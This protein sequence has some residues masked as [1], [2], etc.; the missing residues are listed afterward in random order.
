VATVLLALTG[1]LAVRNVMHERDIANEARATA[2]RARLAAE[3]AKDEFVLHQAENAAETD[4]SRSIAWLKRLSD[5]AL[6]W[7]EVHE[8]ASKMRSEGLAHE[9]RGHRQDIELVVASADGTHAASASDDGTVRWWD[10]ATGGSIELPGHHGPIDAVALSPD[11]RY[12]ASAG[13]EHP[14]L[15]WDP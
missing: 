11:G 7:P 1:V 14:V 13:T 10:L 12:L 9:L 6:E 8:L 3:T 5:P 2:D 4:P 15:L